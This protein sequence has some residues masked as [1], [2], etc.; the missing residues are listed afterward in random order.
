MNNLSMLKTSESMSNISPKIMNV[1]GNRIGDE[2]IS[3]HNAPVG[4]FAGGE[5]GRGSDTSNYFSH[6][7]R[8]PTQLFTNIKNERF[9]YV[10]NI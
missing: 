9:K 4:T 10:K 1:E 5:L 3:T 2:V 8:F 6:S 7:G